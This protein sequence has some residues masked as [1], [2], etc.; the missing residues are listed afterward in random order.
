MNTEGNLNSLLESTNIILSCSYHNYHSLGYHLTL[1][2]HFLT[3]GFVIE[4]LFLLGLVILLL[5]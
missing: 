3:F 1:L 2:L 5:L 4:L